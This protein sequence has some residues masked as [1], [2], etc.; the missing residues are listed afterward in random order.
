MN[1]FEPNTWWGAVAPA[2]TPKE[3]LAKLNAEINRILATAEVRKLFQSQ[4]VQI[5]GGTMDA[6]ADYIKS[7][8]SLWSKVV[9]EARI[10]AE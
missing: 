9:R 5:A 3:V 7:Q 1:G 10:K 2:A 4:D 8:V 6:C